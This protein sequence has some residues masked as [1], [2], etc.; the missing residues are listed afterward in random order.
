MRVDKINAP[1]PQAQV[2]VDALDDLLDQRGCIALD[3]IRVHTNFRKNKHLFAFLPPT[4]N[5]DSRRIADTWNSIDDLFDFAW[6]Q[7]ASA[8]LDHVLNT[9]NDEEIAILVKITQV[10]AE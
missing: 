10:P 9:G 5:A 4:I 1:R 6:S 8:L 7:C 2:G 3:F